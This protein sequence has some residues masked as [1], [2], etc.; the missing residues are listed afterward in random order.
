MNEVGGLSWE[1]EIDV[2][3][4]DEIDYE[5]LRGGEDSFSAQYSEKIIVE[6]QKI[7][8]SVSGWSDLPFEPSF[9]ESFV[10]SIYM[11]DTWGRNY[12]F[13]WFEDT[14]Q[15]LAS[16]FRRVG[17]TGVTEVYV[18]DFF[19]AVY[20]EDNRIGSTD[21]EI[22]GEIFDNDYRDEVMTLKDFINLG[23]EANTNN[24]EIGWRSSMHFV[25]IGKYIGSPDITAEVAADWEEFGQPKTE[26]WVEDFLDKWKALMLERADKLNKAGFDIMILTP[27]WM[28]PD[29]YPYEEV[30]N[31]M[32][33][34]IIR[35]VKE[36][37]NGEVG[38]VVN[39]YGFLEG[40]CGQEDWSQ[41]DY[42]QEADI[43]YYYIYCLLDKYKA[44]DSPSLEEMR[45][46]F[47]EY[48]DDL[49]ERAGEEGV[50]LSIMAVF[51]SYENGINEG[52]VEFNDI[53]NPDVQALEADWQHQADAYEALFQA[54]EGRDSIVRIVPCGYWWDGAMNPE[55][56][57]VR[58]D[59]APSARNKPAEAVFKKWA[60]VL[61]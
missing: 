58:V 11:F 61:K 31:E 33:K 1:V 35:S 40:I 42:Y 24:L 18:N 32:W 10:I 26:E 27:G 44:P 9:S 47:G 21:Y 20:G 38:V 8:D 19:R 45:E 39:R 59:I 46:K 52:L 56:T 50:Q 37:F 36:A 25:D 23:R 16:S 34:D 49:E 55:D 30:A 53:G 5:Y 4:G 6:N 57:E 43:V 12:N 3:G 22:E 13:N 41:Y 7:Y 14:R 17:E 2:E 54:A 60:T 29:Y 28:T 48:L 51:F 15:N